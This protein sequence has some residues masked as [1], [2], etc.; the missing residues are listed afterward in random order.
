MTHRTARRA[1]VALLTPTLL[2]AGC[3]DGG[4]DAEK[5]GTPTGEATSAATD[6]PDGSDGSDG[7]GS[8]GASGTLTKENFHEVVLAAQK[9]AGS[10]RGR[11]ISS[12]GGVVV[13]ME[14][15]ATY[16]GDVLAAHATTTPDSA[17][18]MEMYVVDG[19]LYLRGDGLDAPAGKWIKIDPSDPSTAD[20]SLAQLGGLA[21]PAKALAVLG[22]PKSFERVGSE[23]VEGVE[24]ERY[25]VVI[26]SSSYAEKLGLGEEVAAAM[27]AEIPFDFWVDAENRPIKTVVEIETGGFAVKTEQLYLDYGADVTI[28]APD[29]ADTV[30][31]KGFGQG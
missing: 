31:W 22:A 16:D 6:G 25:K 17:Q 18:Q 4:S 30:P 20:S 10:F 11:T 1:L 26:D 21:D 23:T 12:M 3:G 29:D 5:A 15:E 27:P 13:T 28:T 14:S 2:L 9:E 7:D 19:V 24:T 8:T